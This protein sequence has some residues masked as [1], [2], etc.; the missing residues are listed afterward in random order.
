MFSADV[1]Q[2]GLWAC[3]IVLQAALLLRIVEKNL[4][5]SLRWFFA[6]LAAEVAFGILLIWTPISSV[7]YFHVWSVAQPVL[8]ILRIAA[9]WEL[10]RR[11]VDSRLGKEFARYRAFAAVVML[12]SLA[13]SGFSLRIERYLM[14]CSAWQYTVV[15]VNRGIWTSIAIVAG[16]VFLTRW[17]RPSWL[18][19]R[20]TVVHGALLVALASVESGRYLTVA[21]SHGQLTIVANIVTLILEGLLYALWMVW[22]KPEEEAQAIQDDELPLAA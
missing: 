11:T 19:D 22:L 8:C 7:L 1:L 3:G 15:L 17:I 9:V 13:L 5:Y 16:G 4:L 6:W 14:H 20:N 10:V 2:K 21:Y 18:L 12:C